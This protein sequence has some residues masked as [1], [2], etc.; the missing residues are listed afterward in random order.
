MRKR[1]FL[2]GLVQPAVAFDIGFCNYMGMADKDISAACPQTS[3]QRRSD[4]KYER[5]QRL[6]V[7]LGFFSNWYVNSV[8]N[9]QDEGQDAEALGIAAF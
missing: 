1:Q 5:Q 8:G 2:F 9:E 7:E 6:Y 4:M 3:G